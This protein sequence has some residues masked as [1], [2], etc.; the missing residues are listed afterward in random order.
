MQ[1]NISKILYLLSFTCF[2]PICYALPFNIVP[3]ATLPTTISPGQTIYAYYTVTN[4]TG[5]QRNNNH[6]TYLPSPPNVTVDETTGCTS[7]FNLAPYGH[8]GDS[9]VLKLAV[10]GPVNASDP[11]PHHHLLVCFPGDT[12]CAGTQYPLNVTVVNTVKKMAYVANNS[13]ANTISI[14]SMA[15]DD[16]NIDSCNSFSDPTFN[17]PIAVVLNKKNTMAYIANAGNNTISFCP[18]NS[19]GTLGSC[20]AIVASNTTFTGLT[21]NNDDTY[22]YYTKYNSASVGT[23]PVDVNGNLGTCFNQSPSFANPNG[24]IA[25]NAAGTLAY[26]AQFGNGEVAICSVNTNGQFSSC[27]STGD[28]TFTGLLGVGIDTTN[29]LLFLPND[30]GNNISIC[31]LDSITGS[32]VTCTTSTGN[33]TFSFDG[34]ATNMFVQ[35]LNNVSYAYVPNGGNATVSICPIQGGIFGTCSV[36][37]SSTFQNPDGISLSK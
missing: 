14:C 12:T 20:Q 37:T 11:D 4:N 29:N 24:Q 36:S 33:G 16:I 21:L 13:G 5:S 30:P 27:N 22:I 35:N 8:A 3:A 2:T 1:R 32:I 7:Y 31:S 15:S 9:C 17:S 18:I 10:T 28:P 19:G 34:T 6:V 25:F 23:C 26:V